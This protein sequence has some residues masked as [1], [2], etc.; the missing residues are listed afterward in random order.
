[1]MSLLRLPSSD[2]TGVGEFQREI[3]G[4][5]PVDN[6]PSANY[7]HHFVQKRKKEKL[8]VTPAV[9]YLTRDT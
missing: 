7:L 4:V 3:D 5:D 2:R 8:L 9:V 1:M 6:R